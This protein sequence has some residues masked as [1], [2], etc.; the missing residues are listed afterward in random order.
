MEEEEAA[1]VAAAAVEEA[2][3]VE[4]A[5]EAAVVEAAA[6]EAAAVAPVTGDVRPALRVRASA[7]SDRALV[8]QRPPRNA[9]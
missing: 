9:R 3:A 6:V 2:A 8:A 7:S 1:A 4:A 5:V